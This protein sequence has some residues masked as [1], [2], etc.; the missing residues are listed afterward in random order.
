MKKM[1]A[2]FLNQGR[3][4]YEIRLFLR[5]WY[6]RTALGLLDLFF[7]RASSRQDVHDVFVP[8]GAGVLEH[9]PLHGAQ[10]NDGRPG[11]RP[12]GGVIDGELVLDGVLVGTREVFGNFQRIGIGVLKCGARAEIRGLD[13][14]RIALPM[15]AG[16]T[17]PLADI[18]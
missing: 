16:I 2:A 10:G 5:D 13:D 3:I 18:R 1:P 15:A 14:E 12:S 7:G 9:R 11:S 6:S 17:V 8:F 4:A